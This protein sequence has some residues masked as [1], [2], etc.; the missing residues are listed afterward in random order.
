MSNFVICVLEQATADEFPPEATHAMYR[1]EAI[2]SDGLNNFPTKEEAQ[3][4]LS[5]IE[6]WYADPENGFTIDYQYAF[7]FGAHKVWTKEDALRG[8]K[9]ES[10]ETRTIFWIEEEGWRE[11]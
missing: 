11:K 7:G 6:T 1:V 9:V 4:A 3:K 10:C 8:F 2:N 5:E